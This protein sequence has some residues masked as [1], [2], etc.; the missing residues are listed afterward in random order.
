MLREF[1]ARLA[2]GIRPYDAVGRYGGEEFVVVMPGL[3]IAQVEH[4]ARLAAIHLSIAGSPMSVGTVTCSFGVAGTDGTGPVDVDTLIATADEA[5][6]RAKRNGRNC[7]EWSS[8][9]TLPVKG[10]S[11][12]TV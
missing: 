10:A 8:C 5:L 12:S 4:R 11:L 1:S 2:A 9:A 3:D 7:I 6:Y